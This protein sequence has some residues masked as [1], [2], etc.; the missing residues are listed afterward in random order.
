MSFQGA[1]N[2]WDRFPFPSKINGYK[3]QKENLII[4]INNCLIVSKTKPYVN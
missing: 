1:A 4:E 3:I 2:Y